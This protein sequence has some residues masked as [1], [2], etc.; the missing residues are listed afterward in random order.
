MARRRAAGNGRIDHSIHLLLLYS[1]V[2]IKTDPGLFPVSSLLI[3]LGDIPGI[4]QAPAHE[5]IVFISIIPN[6]ELMMLPGF[7]ANNRTLEEHVQTLVNHW[8]RAIFN[9]HTGILKPAQ[10]LFKTLL[11]LVV[12]FLQHH[13]FRD[14]Q[15]KAVAICHL[16]LG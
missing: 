15:T 12:Q 10:G 11:H 6:Q 13:R 16:Q 14:Q 1:R 4:F 3:L 8:H 9:F 7:I 5:W 2:K